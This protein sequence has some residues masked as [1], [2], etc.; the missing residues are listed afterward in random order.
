M[1]V[2]N[3]MVAKCRPKEFFPTKILTWRVFVNVNVLVC[4]NFWINV[5]AQRVLKFVD[6]FF[7]NFN[8]SLAELR[9]PIL[10]RTQRMNRRFIGAHFRS[11]K[12]V[13]L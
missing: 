7:D 5:I 10:K 2:Y 12:D 13:L 3:Q 4:I 11:Q 6:S 8:P 9:Q 1:A